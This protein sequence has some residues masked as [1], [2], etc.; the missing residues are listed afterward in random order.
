VPLTVDSLAAFPW[1]EGVRTTKK[2]EGGGS[3]KSKG[4]GMSYIAI[5]RLEYGSLNDLVELFC[6]ISRCCQVPAGSVMLIASL[7]HLSDVGFEAY[8]ED[9]NQC[10]M[11]IGRLFKGGLIV[12]PGLL[13]PLSIVTEGMI[14]RYMLK[15]LSW[16]SV[17]SVVTECGEPILSRCYTYLRETL[18]EKG[19]GNVQASNCC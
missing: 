18:V 9:L 4:R 17:I 13:F 8:A 2:V 10:A 6:E 15:L 3:W 19:T 1:E 12:L 14:P 16:S 11:K 5:I 7:S